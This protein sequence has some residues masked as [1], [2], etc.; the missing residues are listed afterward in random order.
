M[1][2]GQ[3]IITA[4]AAYGAN[5]V[6]FLRAVERRGVSIDVIGN[7]EHGHVDVAELANRVDDDVALI[8]LTHVPTNGGLVNPAAKVG[9]IAN[10]A[11]VPFLLDA[12]QSV[13][14]MPVDV[15]E[16]GCDLLSSTGRKYLRGPRGTGFLYASDRMIDRLIPD[17]PDHH[18]ADWT[19]VNT[20]VLQPN[21]QRFESWEFS[22]AGW[23]ALGNAVEEATTIGLDRI[24]ATVVERA[25]SL[26]SRLADAGFTV[27]DLGEHRCGLVTAIRD[28]LDPTEA[29]AALQE[30][31]VNISVTSPTSAR[32]D[33]ASRPLPD[34]M[35]LSVH[36]LTTE[37]ELDAAI[38][39]LTTL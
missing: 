8:A 29:K 4:N 38:R 7:D 16:I 30:H 21:A 37:R 22:H 14:Q 5:A 24:Q 26:R 32:Y 1:E 27:M 2:A 19:D 18:G 9:A 31:D 10:A 15:N 34:M 6:A 17:H 20:L 11:G 39:A 25:A 35:R 23:L 13:G 3:R 12:C 36:Y 33:E 28:G